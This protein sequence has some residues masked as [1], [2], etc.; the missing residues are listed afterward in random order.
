M[1][2]VVNERDKIM[3]FSPQR[4]VPVTPA[5][6]LV[7]AGYTGIKLNS[8]VYIWNASGGAYW[9]QPGSGTGVSRETLSV[10]F[11]GITVSTPVTWRVG[12][13]TLA[14][15]SVKADYVATSFVEQ[16]VSEHGIIVTPGPDP[17][18]KTVEMT[19]YPRSLPFPCRFGVLGGQGGAVYV[20]C[21][22]AGQTFAAHKLIYQH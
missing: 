9:I 10:G 22:W 7:I 15:D 3:R 8:D 1:S 18:V 4:V 2:T 17:N 6:Q 12:K 16:P 20:T 19:S 21:V 5:E 14:W 11:Q 13:V